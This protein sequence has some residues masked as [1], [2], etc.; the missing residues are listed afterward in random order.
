VAAA[1]AAVS[2]G[3]DTSTRWGCPST[4]ASEK[5]LELL[6]DASSSSD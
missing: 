2:A 6:A 4:L 3:Y 1:P 5:E